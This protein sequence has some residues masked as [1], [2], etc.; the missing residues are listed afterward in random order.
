MDV[1]LGRYA[2]ALIP[3]MIDPGL[4]QFE[5]FL[6]LPDPELQ[7][8]ILHAAPADSEFSGLVA[9]VRAFHGLA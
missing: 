9:D 6:A 5:Q 4:G 1:L 7:K 3:K 2:E 8:W